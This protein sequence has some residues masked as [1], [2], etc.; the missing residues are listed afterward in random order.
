MLPLSILTAQKISDL[1]ISGD[2]LPAQIT[3]MAAAANVNVPPINSVNVVLSS[4]SPDLADKSIQLTYPRV[5]LYSDR[6]K[7]TQ[8]E[9]F[10]SFSGT[11]AV[12]AELWAS[13][14]MVQQT[15][16]WIHFYIEAVTDILRTNIGDW[17]DGVF[18]SGVY[19]VQFTSPK[20]GGIGF[21]QSAKV[22]C[23]LNVSRT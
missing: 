16:Q 1:L 23:T 7:N 13:A 17:G 19:D 11:V 9:K 5:C 3:A 22:T 6:I 15:D 4:A 8:A 21:V 20:A 14:N 2:T 18:Y 12:V 10:R